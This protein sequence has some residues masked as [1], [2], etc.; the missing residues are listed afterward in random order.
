MFILLVTWGLVS[1]ITL[2]I[3]AVVLNEETPSNEELCMLST[4]TYASLETCRRSGGACRLNDSQFAEWKQAGMDTAL[5]CTR[6]QYDKSEELLKG[7]EPAKD[8]QT[9]KDDLRANTR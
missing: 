7:S 2:G 3:I 1:L 8:G 4:T 9:D 5:Y 6:M